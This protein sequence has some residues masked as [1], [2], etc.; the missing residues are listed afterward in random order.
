MHMRSPRTRMGPLCPG[1][2]MLATQSPGILPA[3]GYHDEKSHRQL[4][5]EA[6]SAPCFL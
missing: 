4:R 5:V 6:L 2:M 1:D 3:W